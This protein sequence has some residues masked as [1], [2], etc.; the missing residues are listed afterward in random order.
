[1][2]HTG[3]AREG[4]LSTASDRHDGFNII[5]IGEPRPRIREPLELVQ[6]PLKF[7]KRRSLVGV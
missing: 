5:V 2:Y 4:L 1:M 3:G 6:L 7:R